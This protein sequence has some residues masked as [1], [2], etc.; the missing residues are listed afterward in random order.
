MLNP[1]DPMPTIRKILGAPIYQEVIDANLLSQLDD[2]AP[3]Q[4]EDRCHNTDPEHHAG[5]AK[6]L[7]ITPCSHGNYY[8]CDTF[9][10]WLTSNPLAHCARCDAYMPLADLSFIL[11]GGNK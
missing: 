1:F 2:F 9:A 6:Y 10:I 8:V 11:I 3:P 7:F 4:C 5:A